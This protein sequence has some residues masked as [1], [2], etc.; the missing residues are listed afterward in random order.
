MRVRVRERREEDGP[1]SFELTRARSVRP[2]GS[3]SACSACSGFDELAIVAAVGAAA[4][5]FAGG[6]FEGAAGVLVAEEG[7][8]GAAV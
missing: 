2:S 1:A 5:V 7:E 3:S 4:G 6:P 8:L